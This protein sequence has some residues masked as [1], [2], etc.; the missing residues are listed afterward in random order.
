MLTKCLLCLN[1]SSF[2]S[3]EARPCLQDDSTV[4]HH[5]ISLNLVHYTEFAHKHRPAQDWAFLVSSTLLSR[6]IQRNW[7][8]WADAMEYQLN[9]YK[10]TITSTSCCLSKKNQSRHLTLACSRQPKMF[11]VSQHRR[12]GEIQALANRPL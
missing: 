8:C 9:K 11:T 5:Q 1:L 7:F 3:L 4:R 6:H 2:I 10:L 12:S